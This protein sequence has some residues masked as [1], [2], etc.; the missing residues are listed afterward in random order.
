MK[1]F[2]L[3]LS[4]TIISLITGIVV[5]FFLKNDSNQS[6]HSIS[7]ESIEEVLKLSTTEVNVNDIYIYEPTESSWKFFTEK[8]VIMKVSGKVIFGYDLT[9]DN[10]IQVDSTNKVIKLNLSSPEPL[11][12]EHELQEFNR[13]IGLFEEFTVDDNNEMMKRSREKIIDLAKL[14]LQNYQPKNDLIVNIVESLC[15]GYKIEVQ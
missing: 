8:K 6:T 11:Y 4:I 7:V 5:A 13:S 1:K 14:S 10:I 12:V 15:A 2:F 9:K 3:I